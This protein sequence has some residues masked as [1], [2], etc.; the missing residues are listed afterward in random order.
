MKILFI[1]IFLIH[2]KSL[3]TKNESS[4][5]K[6]NTDLY[7]HWVAFDKV[8][9]QEFTGVIEPQNLELNL[10][11][12]IYNDPDIIVDGHQSEYMHLKIR[13]RALDPEANAS[14]YLMQCRI[15]HRSESGGARDFFYPKAC[16]SLSDSPS[17]NMISNRDQ[18]VGDGNKD[19]NQFKTYFFDP[20]FNV[21]TTC[22]YV[23]NSGCSSL[24]EK[25]E[26]VDLEFYV[27][28]GASPQ[29]AVYLDKRTHA[30]Q[31]EISPP[32]TYDEAAELRTQILS[33][34]QNE[35]NLQEYLSTWDSRYKFV[36]TSTLRSGDSAGDNIFCKNDTQNILTRSLSPMT[37]YN[38]DPQSL[39][40]A[41]WTSPNEIDSIKF[42][43]FFKIKFS[44]NQFSICQ[45][46]L[47]K[48]LKSNLILSPHIDN[49]TNLNDF[50]TTNAPIPQ[51]YVF[52]SLESN[53]GSFC[54][55]NYGGIAFDM[56][57]IIIP[58]N[59]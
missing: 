22:N 8:F 3:N 38:E 36:I 21:A 24:A 9:S 26:N 46:S 58:P 34:I 33:Q 2:C 35:V 7:P 20:S 28:Q 25:L 40:L 30:N 41:T 44:N 6:I 1:L 16:I 14:E 32:A 27:Y 57:G 51:L 23:K 39:T 15:Y 54:D 29:E 18:V 52:K 59:S 4:G 47:A 5:L 19:F 55:S 13:K 12:I 48:V 11:G 42:T 43:C 50:L 56:I 37:I 31:T 53:R 49:T 17:V 10:D 45:F